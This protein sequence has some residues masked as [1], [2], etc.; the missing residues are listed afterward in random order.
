MKKGI[1]IRAFSGNP[2][3]LGSGGFLSGLDDFKRCFARARSAGFDAVQPFLEP[4]GFFS[5]ESPPD[6]IEAVA[7]A[8]A[9]EDVA[10]PSL[11]IAPF[12]FSFTTDDA[13]ERTR[14]I[15][16]VT[17][18]IEIASRMGVSGLLVIPGWVGLPWDASAPVVDYDVAYERTRDTLRRLAPI[19]DRLKVRLMLE[20]IWNRFLLSP[21]EM[22]E[23]LDEIE[24]SAVSALLDV[25]NLVAFGYPEQWI[26]I[27]GH[28]IAEIHL[29]D[30]RTSVGTVDGFVDLMSGDVNWT[31]VM[32]ALRGIGYDGYLTAEV[33][34]YAHAPELVIDRTSQAMDAILAL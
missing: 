12:S 19:A 7:A 1:V 21:R 9:A 4:T 23:L 28:R 27:L 15:D 34:P 2:D 31:S 17:R 24:S 20:N 14:A 8:A 26:R 6:I 22:R 33:F 16:H 10:L 13:A 5:L 25:G 29:K 30:Y 32:A 11:E 18:C 3:F